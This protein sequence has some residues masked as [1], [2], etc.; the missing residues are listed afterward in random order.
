MEN[1][2]RGKCGPELTWKLRGRALIIS[3]MGEM[4]DHELP[5]R[6]INTGEMRV[7]IKP[8]SWIPLDIRRLIIK[9]GVTGI[10]KRAF[11][12]CS[13]LEKVV[14]PEGVTHIGDSAFSECR[15]LKEVTIP[16]SVSRIEKW[17]FAS[18]WGLKDVYYA[19]SED[20]WNSIE[21]ISA[22]EDLLKARKHFRKSLKGADDMEATKSG[23]CGPDLYW[24]LH[25]TTLRI[26]GTGRMA[27]YATDPR[28]D[29]DPQPWEDDPI[30][31][32]IMEKGVTS[33][34]VGA[35]F[36]LGTLKS[37]K[38][39]NGVLSIGACAFAMCRSL[40]SINIPDG[41][42]EMGF[43][44]FD[45]CSELT[46]AVIPKS[47]KKIGN[48]AFGSC[49]SLKDVYYAGSKNEWN[50]IEGISAEKD[51]L[52]AQKHFNRTVPEA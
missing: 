17:A 14:I 4:D 43:R 46:Y 12:D 18:C 22:E 23:K 1:K 37:V 7:Y 6:E 44:A 51:L 29:S 5:E 48:S 41:V 39:P 49:Q 15:G 20:E 16:A 38:I 33:I 34:G 26:F 2:K 52:N 47:L 21:G 10:G 13:S 3:G 19:G 35:F 25:G 9:K 36:R 11:A 32:V 30:E 31:K 28:D 50:R 27:W 8:K 42:T 24:E 45:G 40:K